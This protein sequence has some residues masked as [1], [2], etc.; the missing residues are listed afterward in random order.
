MDA[1]FCSVALTML[2][3][4]SASSC[5]RITYNALALVQNTRKISIEELL[6]RSRLENY[7]ATRM[8]TITALDYADP[9]QRMLLLKS[10]RPR[11][12]ANVENFSYHAPYGMMLMGNS[13]HYGGN[14]GYH[15]HGHHNAGARYIPQGMHPTSVADVYAQGGLYGIQAQGSY[16]HSRLGPQMHG[17]QARSIDGY[18]LQG[19]SPHSTSLTPPHTQATGYT[20]VAGYA[21][22]SPFGTVGVAGS[23]NDPYQSYAYG[24]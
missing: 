16:G 9:A 23:L 3:T 5:E 2:R 17:V 4:T 10:I 20:G 13:G 7:F 21:N 11:E 19:T 14:P 6:N 15:G 18:V 1:G 24:M 12:Q 22:V 8:A